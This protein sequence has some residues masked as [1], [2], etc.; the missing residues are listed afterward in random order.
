MMRTSAGGARA[1]ARGRAGRRGDSGRSS[2]RQSSS[3]KISSYIPSHE[4]EEAASPAGGH[5][6][7]VQTLIDMFGRQTCPTAAYSA[8]QAMQC[9]GYA[10]G[11]VDRTAQMLMQ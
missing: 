4:N 11:N 1:D 8:E 10:E 6:N 3:M 5:N 7:A 9:L 2:S